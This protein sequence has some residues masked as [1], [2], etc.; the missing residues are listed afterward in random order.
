MFLRL[1][2][3]IALVV[4]NAIKTTKGNEALFAAPI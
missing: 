3:K 2:S 4:T 1:L